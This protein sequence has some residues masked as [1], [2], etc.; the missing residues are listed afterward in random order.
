MKASTKKN[1]DSLEGACRK[2]W[3]RHFDVC[4]K[5]LAVLRRNCL[6]YVQDQRFEYNSFERERGSAR[7]LLGVYRQHVTSMPWKCLEPARSEKTTKTK[8]LPRT[9]TPGY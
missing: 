1:L 9:E 6:V 5:I 2:E 7:S 8:G 4:D 3:R